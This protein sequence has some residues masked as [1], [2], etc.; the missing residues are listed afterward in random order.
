MNVNWEIVCPD[1]VVGQMDAG[2]FSRV[3]CV[4]WKQTQFTR[5]TLGS[6]FAHTRP[7]YLQPI[8]TVY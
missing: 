8:T 6:W 3:R 7:S 4:T 5:L 2:L 1:R